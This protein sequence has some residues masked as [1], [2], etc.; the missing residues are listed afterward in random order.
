MAFL[1][2]A[3]VGPRSASGGGPIGPSLPEGSLKRVTIRRVTLK[4]VLNRVIKRVYCIFCSGCTVIFAVVGV[5]DCSG[6]VTNCS[7]LIMDFSAREYRNFCSGW[8]G[9]NI[10]VG[11]SLPTAIFELKAAGSFQGRERF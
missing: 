4:R 1:D 2:M 8:E 6:W 3:L 5:T 9:Q 7:A 11:A 10:P